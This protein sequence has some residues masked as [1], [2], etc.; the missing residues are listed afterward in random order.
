MYFK[1]IFHQFYSKICNQD[2]GLDRLLYWYN[3]PNE[4]QKDV[5][6]L[7]NLKQNGVKITAGPLETVD[8]ELFK[9]VSFFGSSGL[10]LRILMTILSSITDHRKDLL[11]NLRII[12][13]LNNLL[14]QWFIEYFPTFAPFQLRSRGWTWKM[15]RYW[16][17]IFCSLN[18]YI[19]LI[20]LLDVNSY[21]LI[22][23]HLMV[24]DG[25]KSLARS[26]WFRIFRQPHHF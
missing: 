24:F 19:T 6:H 3:L 4:L 26:G 9:I 25:R 20:Q 12:T 11:K 17:W 16:N 21:F 1:T 15:S 10:F 7:I 2:N 18:F 22:Q 5:M 13:S 14:P 8:R 23:T